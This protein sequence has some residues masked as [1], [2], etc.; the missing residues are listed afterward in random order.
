[1]LA[2][3]LHAVSAAV[4]SYDFLAAKGL[5]PPLDDVHTAAGHLIGLSH[6]SATTTPDQVN[7]HYRRISTLLR[8]RALKSIV[9]NHN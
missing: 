4:P 1:V 9:V 7:H 6:T 3:R 2:S 5:V 8:I